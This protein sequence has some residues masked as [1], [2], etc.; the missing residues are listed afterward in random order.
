MTVLCRVGGCDKHRQE[1]FVRMHSTIH[2]LILI[3]GGDDNNGAIA[4]SR[5]SVLCVVKLSHLW[6]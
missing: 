2:F 4:Q 3:C 6:E 5:V 1:V